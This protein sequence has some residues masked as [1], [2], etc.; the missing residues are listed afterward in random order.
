MSVSNG[1]GG[2]ALPEW[3]ALVAGTGIAALFTADGE[4]LS[5]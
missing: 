1:S 5:L 4:M 2:I 3:P